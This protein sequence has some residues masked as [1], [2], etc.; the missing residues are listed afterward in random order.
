MHSA[1]ESVTSGLRSP[2]ASCFL[3][4]FPL[5]SSER[6]TQPTVRAQGLSC[7]GTSCRETERYRAAGQPPRPAS[8]PWK[9]SASF[10]FLAVVCLQPESAEVHSFSWF[11][12]KPFQS[13]SRHTVD[14][15]LKKGPLNS[16]LNPLN[17]ELPSQCCLHPGITFLPVLPQ[18]SN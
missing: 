17:L 18:K 9:G 1:L 10:S 13:I 14:S 12:R 3:G 16:Y 7:K 4:P 8:P 2:P 5:N 11:L 15:N 6:H